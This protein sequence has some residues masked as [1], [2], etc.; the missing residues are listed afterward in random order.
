M[1]IIKTELMPYEKFVQSVLNL[2]THGRR[3]IKGVFREIPS[4]KIVKGDNF[5]CIVVGDAEQSYKAA[6]KYFNHLR[7]DDELERVFVSAEWDSEEAQGN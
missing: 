2:V 7:E 3:K 6:I 5:N 4:G 1:D